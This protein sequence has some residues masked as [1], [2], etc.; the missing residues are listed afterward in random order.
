MCLSFQ[1]L[2]HLLTQLHRNIFA[3]LIFFHNAPIFGPMTMFVYTSSKWTMGT[4]RQMYI[5][6]N[7][8]ISASKQDMNN[9]KTTQMHMEVNYS[10]VHLGT[11]CINQSNLAVVNVQ[12]H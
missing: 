2:V 8:N 9:P 4:R 3:S 10:D 7:D 12:S 1:M 5:S 6:L 11:L